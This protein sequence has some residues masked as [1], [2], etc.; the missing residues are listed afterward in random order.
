MTLKKIRKQKCLFTFGK[1]KKNSRNREKR[2]AENQKIKT[3]P[4]SFK[5][6]ACNNYYIQHP[7]FNILFDDTDNID[8]ICPELLENTYTFSLP[9]PENDSN[10]SFSTLLQKVDDDMFKTVY[11]F[12]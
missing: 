9:Q 3:I 10:V 5:S 12:V 8:I 4:Q 6:Y 11:T 7:Y 2:I 1:I